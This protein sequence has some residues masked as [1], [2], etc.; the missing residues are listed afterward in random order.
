M[1]SYVHKSSISYSDNNQ[2]MQLNRINNNGVFNANYRH[3]NNLGGLVEKNF[4]NEQQLNDFITS[5]NIIL[6]NASTDQISKESPSSLFMQPPLNNYDDKPDRYERDGLD[7]MPYYIANI[8][9][10]KSKEGLLSSPAD[11]SNVYRKSRKRGTKKQSRKIDGK[12]RSICREYLGKKI[13]ININEGVYKSRAQAI[14]VAYSQVGK[15]YP[16]CKRI[17][18]IRSKKSKRRSR[19]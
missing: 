4:N 12:R 2:Q 9:S 13:G 10:K 5:Y 16:Q 15:K 18:R 11:S 1:N 6:D 3:F 8:Y 17:L 19:K 14:A 7:N